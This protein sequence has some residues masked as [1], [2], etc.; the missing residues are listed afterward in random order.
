MFKVRPFIAAM[1]LGYGCASHAADF[2][3]TV[4]FGDSLTDSGTYAS[5]PAIAGLFPIEGKFT[6]NPGPV[7]SEIIGAR[8]GVAVTPA[9]QGGSNYAAGGARVSQQPGYP[10]NPLVPFVQVATPVSSQID[11]FLASNNG[12]A[13]GRTL[14]SVWAGANDVFALQD[15]D[16]SYSALPMADVAADLSS[17]IIRLRDAGAKTIVV[18]N[19][20]DIGATAAAQSGTE[21]ER[22]SGTLFAQTFN[23]ALFSDLADAG[24]AVIPVDTFSLLTQVVADA[25]R[26]GISNTS[27]TAC[28]GQPSSLVCGP[29]DYPAGADQTYLFAD[30]V[31]PTSVTHGILADHVLNLLAAPAQ[32]AL[33]ADR[34]SADRQALHH[35]LRTQLAASQDSDRKLWLSVSGGN[36]QRDTRSNDPGLEDNGYQ[37]SLGVN[38]LQGEHWQLGGAVSLADSDSDFEL[39]RGDYATWEMALSLYG[40]YQAGPWV[41]QGVI[42]YSSIDYELNRYNPLG[43]YGYN[44]KGK[45]DGNNLSAEIETAY[46]LTIGNFSTG[47]VVGLQLQQITI[48]SFEESGVAAVTLGFDNLDRDILLGKVGWQAR[49]QFNALSPFARLSYEENFGDDESDIKV[50]TLSVANALPFTLP[51]AGPDDAVIAAEIGLSGSTSAGT[52]FQVSVMTRNSSDEELWV[53]QGGFS[54]PF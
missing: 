34:S 9:N 48:D 18:P 50:T 8:F 6:T 19:L 39:N 29:D 14:Y 16:A 47:P 46:W 30:G 42:A 32:V 2:N 13:D 54:F 27:G 17:A 12:I 10:N 38:L 22:E 51:A 41:T 28:A 49:W 45:T 7:W 23:D 24:V 11:N 1:A 15:G 53:V 3:N 31:H 5:E 40:N 43:V 26:F 25:Q 35:L 20:P 52:G 37:L 4:F 36:Y 33:L 21:A 44:A